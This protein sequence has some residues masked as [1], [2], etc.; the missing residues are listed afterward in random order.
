MKPTHYT[1]SNTGDWFPANRTHIEITPE[2]TAQLSPR[3]LAIAKACIGHM[4]AASLIN[5]S[6]PEIELA[7]RISHLL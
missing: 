5:P 2:P 4:H 6:H 3:A 1:L 7:K